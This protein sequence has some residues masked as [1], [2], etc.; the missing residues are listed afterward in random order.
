[1]QR[2]GHEERLFSEPAD[3]V[4]AVSLSR[5]EDSEIL[6]KVVEDSRRG[7]CDRLH[8]V[9]IGRNAVHEV[10]CAG[11]ILIESSHFTGL[12]KVLGVGPVGPLFLQLA[13]RI[14]AALQR[15][16]RFLQ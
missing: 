5:A 12:L 11:A 3:L 16:Q 10:E 7:A 2:I 8:A 13:V 9:V 4:S 14:A 6:V 15:F 1:M